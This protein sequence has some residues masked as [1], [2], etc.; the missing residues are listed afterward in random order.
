MKNSGVPVDNEVVQKENQLEIQEEGSQE[1]FAVKRGNVIFRD[2]AMVG[3]STPVLDAM[4]D[5]RPGTEL[6]VKIS[7]PSSGRQTDFLK[8]AS[9]EAERSPGKWARNHLPQVFYSRD[10]AFDESSTILSVTRLFKNA[11]FVT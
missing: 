10:V 1:R 11:E 5:Q 7:W 8:K 3:R 6:V 2:P 4:S 9:E